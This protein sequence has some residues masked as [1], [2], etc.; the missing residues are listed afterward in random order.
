MFNLITSKMRK[1][2]FLTAIVF[3]MVLSTS[4]DKTEDDINPTLEKRYPEWANLTWVE[5]YVGDPHTYVDYPKLSIKIEGNVIEIIELY[6]NQPDEVTEFSRIDFGHNWVEFKGNLNDIT[7]SFYFSKD[8]T[9]ITL[10][11]L[12]DNT[13]YKLK[14]N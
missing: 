3:A 7:R 4:C 2:I 11:T 12:D 8:D 1:L 10:T 9:Y 5:T 14:I 6:R 13:H